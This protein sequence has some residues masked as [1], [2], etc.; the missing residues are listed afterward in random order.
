MISDKNRNKSIVAWNS[1]T[2]LPSNCSYRESQIIAEKNTW[3]T[4]LQVLVF[5]M[6]TA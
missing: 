4:N 6:T 1:V 3:V 2:T 5:F